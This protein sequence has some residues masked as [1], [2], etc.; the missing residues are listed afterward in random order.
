LARNR[1]CAIRNSSPG[2]GPASPKGSEPLGLEWRV[3]GQL[4]R[5]RSGAAGLAAT[6]QTRLW[7]GFF[8]HI[9]SAR[10]ARDRVTPARA[11]EKEIPF[12][13]VLPAQEA[14]ERCAR[15]GRSTTQTSNHT[16]ARPNRGRRT[17]E[18]ETPTR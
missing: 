2:R 8:I 5:H 9:R 17:T 12:A 6:L 11:H 18:T 3:C 7:H 15:T 1:R 4:P 16:D 14:P 13:A 10:S